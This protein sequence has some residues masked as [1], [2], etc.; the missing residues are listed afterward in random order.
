[1]GIGKL[2]SFDDVIGKNLAEIIL[3]IFF[4]KEETYLSITS[5]IVTSLS[6]AY[7]KPK[8]LLIS[9]KDILTNNVGFTIVMS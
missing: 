9:I 5:M 4:I 8:Q 1:M 7:G 6:K 2:H 3:D